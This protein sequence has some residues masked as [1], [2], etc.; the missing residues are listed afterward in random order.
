MRRFQEAERAIAEV[1]AEACEKAGMSAREV[2]ALM[3]APHN[4]VARFISRTRYP[5][6]AELM[7]IG[8]VLGVKGAT[9]LARAEKRLARHWFRKPSGNGVRRRAG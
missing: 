6:S 3:G 5:S 7:A 8:Q 9:L 1:I 4:Y 2:A